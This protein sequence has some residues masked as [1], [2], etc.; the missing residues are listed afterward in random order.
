[1]ETSYIIA[2]I[3]IYITTLHYHNSPHIPLCSCLYKRNYH[4]IIHLFIHLLIYY[5]I[6][7]FYVLACLST[8][9]WRFFF[10]F[11]FLL[12]SHAST[13]LCCPSGSVIW[14][15]HLWNITFRRVESLF[16]QFV[17]K[18]HIHDKWVCGTETNESTSI[19]D[20]ISLR[21]IAEFGLSGSNGQAQNVK[22]W[23]VASDLSWAPRSRVRL[24]LEPAL[25]AFSSVKRRIWKG[26]GGVIVEML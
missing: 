23:T 25:F 22:I 10:F 12:V 6:F 16:T 2:G 4:F 21:Y 18:T 9:K 8:R 15:R 11:F 3:G 1:M 13:T 14:I 24:L 26:I 5:F 20:S 7:L 19:P 17:L